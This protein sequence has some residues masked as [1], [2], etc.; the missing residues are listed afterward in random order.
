MS[1]ESSLKVLLVEDSEDERLLFR[2]GSRRSGLE[3]DLQTVS[4]CREAIDY[5][6]ARGHYGNRGVYPIPDL[7]V[8]DLVLPGMDG[9]GFLAWR[10]ANPWCLAIP[11]VAFS[12]MEGL[13]WKERA[14]SL[15]AD[16]FVTKPFDFDT[17]GAAVRQICELGTKDGRKA[18]TEIDSGSL[19][20]A[21]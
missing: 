17:W 8:L 13:R 3:I 10:M 2:I 19:P 18:P 1:A 11:V 12:G 20:E 14:L 15:G 9:L 6:E 7:I 21:A 5:L 4:S 16:G